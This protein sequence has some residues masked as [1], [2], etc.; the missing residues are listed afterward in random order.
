MGRC[1]IHKSRDLTSVGHHDLQ[2]KALNKAC[3]VSETNLQASAEQGLIMYL[4]GPVN[5][6]ENWNISI[7]LF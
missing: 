6:V 2:I 7:L 4:Y 1:L 5:C 3:C